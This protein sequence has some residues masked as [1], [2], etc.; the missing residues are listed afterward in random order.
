MRKKFKIFSI[1]LGILVVLGVATAVFVFSGQNKITDTKNFK[2]GTLA[3]VSASGVSAYIATPYA[4]NKETSQYSCDGIPEPRC[5]L[6]EVVSETHTKTETQLLPYGSGGNYIDLWTD[7]QNYSEKYAGRYGRTSCTQRYSYNS[8]THKTTINQSCTGRN[9][10][11]DTNV[12]SGPYGITGTLV[13]S[14]HG[15]DS[16]KGTY[17][18]GVRTV[19]TYTPTEKYTLTYTSTK[20]LVMNGN[21]QSY[22]KV[23]LSAFARK[24]SLN[25]NGA[26]PRYV[27]DGDE[28]PCATLRVA[29]KQPNA[30]N[31]QVT[32]TVGGKATLDV[33]P[34]AYANAYIS[35]VGIVKIEKK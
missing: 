27:V 20:L 30:Y 12:V 15:G 2:N 6:G 32:V 3:A 28:I 7:T 21:P 1:A 35:L 8:Q 18:G 24:W 34:V 19:D 13:S 11:N 26:N 29:G 25:K 5:Q 16:S 10:S 17:N 14:G 9:G 31:C 4:S 33:T 22:Y 23:T